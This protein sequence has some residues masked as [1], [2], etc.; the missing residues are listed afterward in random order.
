MLEGQRRNPTLGMGID[1]P[2]AAVAIVGLTRPGQPPMPYKVAE[3]KNIVGRAGRLGLTGR[4]ESFLVPEG[5]LDS[6]RAWNLYVNGRLEDVRSQLMPDG[7]ARSLILRF[8]ARHAADAAGVIAESSVL[9]FLDASFAAFQ[10][11]EGGM[12][13]SDKARLVASFDQLVSSSL[14]MSEGDG[15][16]LTELGRFTGESGVHVDS[17]V[18]LAHVLRGVGPHL[19]SVGLITAAQLT[20]DLD[21]VYLLVNAKAKNTEVPRWPRVLEQQGVPRTL[22]RALGITA[23]DTRRST[24]RAKRAAA[25]AMWVSRIP[26]ET[27]ERELNQHMYQQVGLAGP[28]RA[29]ADRTRDLLPAVGAVLQELHSD[30]PGDP[31]VARTMLRLELGIQADLIEL[32]R[33]LN[34]ALTRPQWA[35]LPSSGSHRY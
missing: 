17:I 9:D 33:V 10:A 20:N 23:A 19:N 29:I 5:T 27:I 31:L 30:R 18:R 6:A 12:A 24:A 28:V 2:A 4:G 34:T 7:D 26:M 35:R 8:L 15:F 11:R 14:I 32:A 22:I 1:T 21:G 16:R 13:Q 3:Y 25:A